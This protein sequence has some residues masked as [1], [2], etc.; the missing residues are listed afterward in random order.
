MPRFECS[1]GHRKTWLQFACES[2]WCRAIL[3]FTMHFDE[4]W[5]RPCRNAPVP[6]STNSRVGSSNSCLRATCSLAS[7]RLGTCLRR[8][9]ALRVRRPY[10]DAKCAARRSSTLMAGRRRH[11]LWNSVEQQN[12][13]AT[14]TRSWPDSSSLCASA[15]STSGSSR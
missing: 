14:L 10:E 5:L 4:F 6:R 1:V 15:S 12:V 8:P 9:S 7:N 13:I 11:E 3:S 2:A